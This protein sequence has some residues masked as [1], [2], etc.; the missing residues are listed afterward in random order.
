MPRKAAT[1]T[2]VDLEG[3]ID[4]ARP[5]HRMIA[6]TAR[7]SSLPQASPVT[8]GVDGSGRIVIATYPDRAK[9]GNARRRPDV[10]VIVLSDDWDGPWVQVDGQCEVLDPPDAVE[11]LVDYYRCIA[12]EHPDWDEYRQAMND[13]GKS[14]MRITPTSWGPIATGG[15]PPRLL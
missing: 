12:G 9:A 11:A 15:F 2:E 6:I 10:S 14:L 3:L 7:A 4:F 13:Q 8:G 1:T 5:R